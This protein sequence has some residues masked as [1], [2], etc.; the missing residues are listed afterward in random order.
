[1]TN[2]LNLTKS[3]S[4]VFITRIATFL[5]GL[6]TGIIIAR[7]LGPQGKG[8][9]SLVVLVPALLYQ[10]G[11]LGLGAANIYFTGSKRFSLTDITSNSLVFGLAVG[12]FLPILFIPAYELFLHPFFKDVE[13]IL[14]YLIL[15]SVPFSFISI[16]FRQIL[17]AKFK[18]KEFNLLNVLQA[19]LVLA[20]VALLLLL[21]NKGVF[22]LVL[23]S[24]F[25]PAIM[26]GFSSFLVSKLTKLRFLLKTNILKESLNYGVKAHLA[27]IFTFLNYRLDMLLVSY[28]IGATQV[29]FYAIAVG[30][31][32]L[33]WLISNAVQTILFPKVASSDLSQ[34]KEISATLGRHTLFLSFLACLGLAIIGKLAIDIVYGSAFLPSFTPLLIL[35]PGILALSLGS[36][37]AAY[38]G[39]VGRP[40][41]AMYASLGSLI[42]NIGLNLVFIPKWGIAGAALATTISY[43][44]MTL[45]VL[46]PYL[47][48]SQNRLTDMVIMKPDDF[49]P[50]LNLIKKLLLR[51]RK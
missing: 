21:L 41:F 13:P 9:Y 50:Y 32:E 6:P 22:A 36:V 5:L 44:L 29:G 15:L 30:I 49:R 43:T 27:N 2:D 8:I 16:Y 26:L 31:A 35:L 34:S 51:K 23:L 42:V 25:I 7:V 47:K 20:G 19:V 17:L 33:V 12:V 38:L 1:M 18:I 14:I 10:L 48:M 4:E 3:I 11:N 37:P 28:F 24:I 46:V 39:G 40:I 45:I